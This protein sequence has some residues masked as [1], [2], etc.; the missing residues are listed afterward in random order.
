MN[1]AI[2]KNESI[3]GQRRLEGF[4]DTCPLFNSLTIERAGLSRYCDVRTFP[5]KSTIVCEGDPTDML[6][7]ILYDSRRINFQGR[8]VQGGQ[9]RQFR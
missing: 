6:Y 8:R 4:A 5:P 9:D 7:F 3:D 1:L 2:A